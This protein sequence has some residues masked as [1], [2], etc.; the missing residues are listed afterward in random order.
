MKL[1]E[2]SLALVLAGMVGGVGAQSEVSGDVPGADVGSLLAYARQHH[3][4]LAAMRAETQAA[5]ARAGAADAMPDPMLKAEL[6]DAY[7]A[8]GD[9]GDRRLTMVPTQVAATRYTLS[10]SLPWWG[11]RGLRREVAEARAGEAGHKAESVWREL[12]RS[13]R[14]TFARHYLVLARQGFAE[15]NLALLAQLEQVARSRYETGLGAQQDLI[16]VQ[17]ERSALLG[18][19]AGMEGERDELAARTRALIGVPGRLAL[20]VPQLLPAL[21]AALP[22]HAAL[23]ALV[24]ERNPQLAADEARILAAEKSREL[25]YKER[26][27]DVTLGITPVQTRSRVSAG[28][29]MI[30]LNIPLQQTRRRHEE[31]EA[32]AMLDAARSRRS[33]TVNDLLAELDSAL[34]GLG[35]ARRMDEL[36]S[37]RLLPQAELTLQAARVGYETGKVDFATVLDA[38]RQVRKAREDGIKARVE[39][40]SR[41]ADIERLTGESK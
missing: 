10:Q 29:V 5:E 28:D 38:Q 36:I 25:T 4:E 9:E 18:E 27:P 15:S 17:T 35:A 14:Q 24:R 6:V 2:W 22:E 20:A 21:P 12:A 16:R 32:E 33:A 19:L 30:E 7:R 13:I 41:L 26:Y 34:A 8:A 23:E 40:V 31:R 39:Q 37:T 1:K 11:K 3:P